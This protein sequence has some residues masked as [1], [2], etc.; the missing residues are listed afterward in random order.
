MGLAL[1]Y[2]GLNF[3]ANTLMFSGTPTRSGTFSGAVQVVDSVG[4]TVTQTV[5]VVIHSGLVITNNSVLP[6]A[7]VGQMYS[8][9][10]VVTNGIPFFNWSV[11]G[12]VLPPGL[13]LGTLSGVLSGVPTAAGN[14]TFQ[15]QVLDS[16][17]NSAQETFSLTVTG[18]SFTIT[19]ASLP[20]AFGPGYSQALTASGGKIPYLVDCLGKFTCGICDKCLDRSSN[21]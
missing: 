20:P 12:G 10:L 15:V 9:T 7:V 5:T 4:T 1:G 13:T 8:Q 6:G 21:G 17:P 19:T 14:F 18:N 3:Y 16:V 11:I 2:F